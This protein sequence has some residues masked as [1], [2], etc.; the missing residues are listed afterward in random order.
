MIQ[1]T[2]DGGKT[3][4]D[5]TPPTMTPFMKVFNM[6][7]GHFDALTAYAAGNTLR[8]D[9]MRPHLFRTHDGGKTWTEINR[10]LENAGP[11]STIREDPKQ[12]GLLYAG[13]ERHVWVSF[14][15]GDNWQ[16]LKLNMA[17]SSVR[18]VMVK[19]DDLIAATHGR[20]FWI[21][22][23]VTPLRQISAASANQDAILF[24][25]ATA[26]R[27]RWNTNSDTPLPPDEPNMPNPPEGAL[28]DYYLKSAAS[29]PVVLEILTTDGKLVRR[30]SSADPVA[31]L[32]DPTASSLP[33][34]WYRP[35]QGLS[36]AP[37]MHRFPWDVHYQPLGSGRGR[38]RR[39]LADRGRAVQHGESAVDAVGESGH[40]HGQAHG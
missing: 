18:D 33:L 14:D 6:D 4:T 9:D 38:T 36:A 24:K 23:D 12:K 30:Y 20:G 8:T 35:P 10:G 29:G 32:P 26:L 7:A 22:D 39:R 25:P 16:T 3:W 19:D 28:I 15:D 1:T 17:S 37:G 13:S 31:P 21:L 11:T 34:Y 5:V 2:A 40:V 27:V